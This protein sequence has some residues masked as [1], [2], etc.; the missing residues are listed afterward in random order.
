MKV[1]LAVR[2]IEND[3]CEIEVNLENDE[4]AD[5]LSAA[6]IGLM[7]KDKKIAEAILSAGFVYLEHNDEVTEI[8]R[9]TSI[10]VPPSNIR[11]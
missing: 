8:T 11:S 2:Q 6:L 5:V 1:L 9:R 4:M 3:I 7:C 10:P